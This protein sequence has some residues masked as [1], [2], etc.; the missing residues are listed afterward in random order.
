MTTTRQLLRY[1][2]DFTT[3]ANERILKAAAALTPEE[4]TRD[5]KTSDKSV[6]GTLAH[7]F[8]A[9]RIWIKRLQNEKADFKVEGDD[10]LAALQKNWPEVRYGWTEWARTVS[11][12]VINGDFKY[13][14]LKGN[15]W[16]QPIS[17]IIMHVTNHSSHHRGQAVGFIR[18]MGHQP[19]NVDLITF[20]RERM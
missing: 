4:L 16:S 12:D 3:W 13:S 5:F 17:I 6:L 7:C 18:S 8:R 15:A 14:D 1:Q 10:T 9:E 20:S 19:P 11:D 2:L